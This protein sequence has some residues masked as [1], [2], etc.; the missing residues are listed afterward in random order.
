VTTSCS[1]RNVDLCR[2]LGA[3]EVLDYTQCDLV[4]ELRAKGQAFDLVIDFVGS[5]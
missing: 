2:S 3:D 1:T 4:G 5:P